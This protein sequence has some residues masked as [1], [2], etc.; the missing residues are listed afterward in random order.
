MTITINSKIA[1]EYLRVNG[2][3]K[4]LFG[5]KEVFQFS[6]QYYVCLLGIVAIFFAIKANYS[7]VTKTMALLLALSS[8]ILVFA[9]FWRFLV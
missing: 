3:T 8:I 9:R 7:R 5:L 6:Y 2:K 1:N 4:A